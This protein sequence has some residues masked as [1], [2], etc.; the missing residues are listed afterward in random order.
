[1][2]GPALFYVSSVPMT[3]LAAI[4]GARVVEKVRESEVYQNARDRVV[5]AIKLDPPA[6][7]FEVI[8]GGAAAEG[9][10]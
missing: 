1:M 9:S 10:E 5:D 7:R 2:F 6:E 4:G 8:E 3:I